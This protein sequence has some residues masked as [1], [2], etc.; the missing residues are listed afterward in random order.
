MNVEISTLEARVNTM[1][2]TIIFHRLYKVDITTNKV[3]LQ[4]FAE[5][6]NVNN[7]VMELLKDVT[8][9][10]G[11]REYLFED[12][13]LSMKTFLNNI[14]R[15][16]D[17]NDNSELIGQRLLQKEKNAQEKVAQLRR[18][19][20]KGILII[21]YVQMTETE[22]KIII[23]KADYNEFLELEVTGSIR[24][25]LPTKKK[26]F[27]S[28]I[29]NI[30]LIDGVDTITK[31]VTYDLNTTKAAYW[32]K[33][34]LELK[35]IRDDEKNTLNAYNSIKVK[36]LDPIR[37]KHKRDWLC[38]SNATVAYFRGEGDF[39]FIHFR[40]NIIGNYIPNDP[41]LDMIE[42]KAKINKLPTQD[43]FDLR[44]TKKPSVVKD[45]IKNVI[46]LTD[47]ID[48]VIKHDVASVDAT[49]K[50]YEDGEGK[51]YLAIRSDKGFLYVKNLQQ[52]DENR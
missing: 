8:E 43:K 46:S 15:N 33:E 37:K 11:D 28:F 18:Q 1:D 26:I 31:L 16:I 4:E 49:F 38:L 24:N 47:E 40:D 14:I 21:S 30:S 23:S 13:S 39:D 12:G 20:L 51:K 25:G 32:W 48:L 22:Y 45:K 19:I 44:F 27:K 29:A 3:T 42:L 36:I 5:N 52:R 35:E 50:A 7:Y 2:V 41:T 6:N 9:N 17:R 10:E 34:F